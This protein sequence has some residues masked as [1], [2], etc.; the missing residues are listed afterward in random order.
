VKRRPRATSSAAVNPERGF[1][2]MEMMI[3]VAVIGLLAAAAIVFVKPGQF[4][5]SS[6]GYAHQ[7]AALVEGVRQ[8]AVASRTYQM[9]EVHDDQVLHYQGATTGMTMP[10]DWNLIGTTPALHGVVIAS[11]SDR[12]HTETD[13]GVPAAGAGLPATIYFPP[14]GTASPATIFVTDEQDANRARVAIYRA[15]A[16]AYAFN[17]W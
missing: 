4:A 12:T 11:A 6:R 3:V 15:T 17:E 13:D 14:D 1:T 5:G 10:T 9:L 2:L 16:S 7:I 8:R